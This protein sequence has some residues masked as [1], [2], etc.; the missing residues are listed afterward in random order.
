MCAGKEMEAYSEEKSSYSTRGSN[1]Q[2]KLFFFF[3]PGGFGG[4]VCLFVFVCLFWF[5]YLFFVLFFLN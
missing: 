1:L 2:L 5:G 4:F 3:F